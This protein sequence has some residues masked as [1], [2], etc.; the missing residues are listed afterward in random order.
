MRS[1]TAA[2]I[3]RGAESVCCRQASENQYVKPDTIQCDPVPNPR[4]LYLAHSLKVE[5]D[6]IDAL[7]IHRLQA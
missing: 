2:V 7:I 3:R 6:P 5:P 4:S 1:L